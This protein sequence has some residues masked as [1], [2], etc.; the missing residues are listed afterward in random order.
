MGTRTV[1]AVAAATD[2][3]RLPGHVDHVPAISDATPAKSIPS[4]RAGRAWMR[5]LPGLVLLA[6]TLT[7]ILQNLRT[8]RVTFFAASGTLPIALALLAAAA[9]GA[10]AVLALG[11]V[12]IMQLRKLV[13]HESRHDPGDETRT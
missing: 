1:E 9:L 6:V 8:A 10:L 2:P 12:R 5:V 11:S 4:T 13:R 3:V 7:F